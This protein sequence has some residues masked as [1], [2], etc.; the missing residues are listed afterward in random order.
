MSSS[1]YS[2]IKNLMTKASR[3][4]QSTCAFEQ[5]QHD[6]GKDKTKFF[7]CKDLNCRTVNMHYTTIPDANLI[8]NNP[9]SCKT[10][11]AI[12]NKCKL[13]HF[14]QDCE[15]AHFGNIKCKFGFFC[16]KK[17]PRP[18]GEKYCLCIHP[19]T[20]AKCKK[21][22]WCPTRLDRV[23]RLEDAC[24][25]A[26]TSVSS[27][28]NYTNCTDENCYLMHD[29]TRNLNQTKDCNFGYKCF[30]AECN[31]MHPYIN[32]CKFDLNCNNKHCKYTHSDNRVNLCYA[33]KSCP[34]YHECSHMSHEL[35]D[36]DKV[37]L[38]KFKVCRPYLIKVY[39]GGNGSHLDRMTEEEKHHLETHKH[40]D[41]KTCGIFVMYD[42]NDDSYKAKKN[43]KKDV[44]CQIL[45]AM[46]D[47][48]AAKENLD[49]DT[50]RAYKDHNYRFIHP[51]LKD[52]TIRYNSNAQSTAVYK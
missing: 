12:T 22:L 47:Y 14:Y 50:F 20:V 39:Y 4:K 2:D 37:P 43:C 33:R 46:H 13:Y 30:N 23:S 32:E 41:V 24:S 29:A 17:P 31:F 52:Y 7:P 10:L 15:K 35:T 19:T 21:D 5:V 45:H 6:E 3:A 36:D 8:C 48:H 44:Q 49:E 38:C 40:P 42:D 11:F 28:S 9:H 18:D 51:S 27:C 34:K 1:S 26:H 16:N 25:F